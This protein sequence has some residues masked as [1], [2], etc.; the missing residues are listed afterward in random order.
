VIKN[1]K[2]ASKFASSFVKNMSDCNGDSIIGDGID[3]HAYLS[4][5]QTSEL[6]GQVS[7]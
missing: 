7:R 5:P 3:Q 4:L 2:V 1:T 6:E